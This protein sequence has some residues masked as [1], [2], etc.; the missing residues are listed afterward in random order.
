MSLDINLLKQVTELAG[1]PG[2]EN[3][4]RN[5]IQKEISDLCD[6][7]YVDAIGNLI[8]VKKGKS[9]KKVMAAAHM[10][11]ISFIVSHVEAE[12]GFIRFLPL[13]GFD[14][15]TLVAQRVIIH[16]EKGD[17]MGVMGCKP[18]H[19]MTPAER[20]KMP[21]I[22]DFYIDTGYSKEEVNKMVEVGDAITRE[23]A[24][25]EMGDCI[26]SKSLDN[27]ISVYILIEALRALKGK[28]IPYDFYAVFSVQEE[29]GLRGATTAASGV[30]PDFG[31]VLDVTLAN[32]MPGAMPHEKVT[33][34]G[35][36]AAIKV[37][38]GSIISDQRMVKYLKGLSKK[39]EIKYQIE[40]L[41]AGG[42]DGAA[43]QRAGSGGSITGGISIPLRYLHQS[44]EMAHKD[45]V[46]AVIDLLILSVEH[47][48]KYDWELK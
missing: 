25:I 47:M 46:T 27:R 16:T 40:L 30:N 10:D 7:Q 43:L 13:G 26:N 18:I 15:K 48:D 44:I 23:R 5:F 11:E 3:R 29:V 19:V 37:L 21:E 33:C 4:I 1:A 35:K 34:L 20:K 32:D 22:S 6:E 17:V 24:L 2:F 39:E 14:P 36:G 31:I 28:K 42:T 9:D 8:A 12:D 38:D 41:P 45:D